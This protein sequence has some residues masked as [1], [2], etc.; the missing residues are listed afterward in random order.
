MI[1][2]R[3]GDPVFILGAGF[4]VDAASEAGFQRSLP[5]SGQPACYPLVSDLLAVCFGIERLPDN[6]NSIEEL[7]QDSIDSGDKEPLK[8]LYNYLM[9][10][11]YHVIWPITPHVRSGGRHYNNAYVKFLRD[12]KK[13]SL[14]TFNYDSLLEILLLAEGSWYPHDGYGVHV[15][16]E[17]E[18]FRKRTPPEEKSLRHVVH[19]HGSLCI[20]TED[21]SI[22]KLP[23]SWFPIL[24]E[25]EPKFLFDPDIIGKCFSPFLR[26]SPSIT[27]Y[28][29]DLSNRIIAPIPNKTEGLKEAFIETM[30]DLAV[31]FLNNAGKIV[32]IGYSFNP[33]DSESYKK[34]LVPM[35][36]KVVLLVAPGSDRLK[37]RLANE[38]SNIRWEA[39]DM[40]FKEWA[41]K[42]YPRTN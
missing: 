4:N 36:G 18:L 6:F 33:Y 35:A 29:P 3:V 17:R 31:E 28:T 12:F 10:L 2:N 24:K 42:G 21:L 19:L 30:Y 20:Y 14:I 40:S 16:V 27:S 34:L 23:G 26:V 38:Y 8:K 15:K 1:D 7:F 37:N 41:E 25:D 32:V 11:D 39:Q 13:S 9:E 5:F 22:E